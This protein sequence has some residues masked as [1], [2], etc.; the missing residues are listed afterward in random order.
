MHHEDADER[1]AEE[2]AKAW[3]TP[4]GNGAGA[5]RRAAAEK[6]LRAEEDENQ[7]DDY[8]QHWRPPVVIDAGNIAE[9]QEPPEGANGEFAGV[10]VAGLWSCDRLVSPAAM[11]G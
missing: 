7:T 6:G 4:G 2:S 11:S 9:D 8:P 1:A 3:E 10:P 5:G